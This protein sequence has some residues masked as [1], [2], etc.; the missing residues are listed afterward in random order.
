MEFYRNR[1]AHAFTL[2]VPHSSVRFGIIRDAYKCDKA[3][4]TVQTVNMKEVL[5]LKGSGA[6][7][8]VITNTYYRCR[9]NAERLV[10]R[11]LEFNK[12]VATRDVFY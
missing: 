1:E 9:K 3:L 4:H 8:R 6:K 10:L 12:L 5:I 11:L 7:A 2:L